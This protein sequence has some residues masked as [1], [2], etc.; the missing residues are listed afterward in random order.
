MSNLL[1]SPRLAT[2]SSLD[3]NYP[4]HDLPGLLQ[5]ARVPASGRLRSL[6]LT[7]GRDALM[8]F[9]RA[10]QP[11]LTQLHFSGWGN[12]EPDWATL[13][14]ANGVEGLRALSLLGLTALDDTKAAMLAGSPR[15]QGLR[16]L[17]V[18]RTSLTATGLASLF[19]L[20]LTY[21]SVQVGQFGTDGLA[22][23]ADTRCR[24]T[25]EELA[26]SLCGG[27]RGWG[28]TLPAGLGL[29]RLRRVALVSCSLSGAG[30]SKL[31]DTPFL[32]GLDVLDL[33]LNGFGAKGLSALTSSG[34]EG[35]RL[36]WLDRC[37]LGDAGM[38]CLARWPGLARVR[39][40]GLGCNRITRAGLI[41]LAE[42][43]HI[44]P[45]E[46]LDLNENEPAMSDG[47][48]ALFR[49]PAGSRLR[50]LSLLGAAPSAVRAITAN[51]PETLRELYLGPSCTSK[52]GPKGMAALRARL[53]ECAIG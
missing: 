53:P 15:L 49:S 27:R 39:Y 3:L 26:L 2:V 31:A 18:E 35:P 11:G 13:F 44:T 30:L 10:L 9:A 5:V 43:P 12:H 4:E 40:L 8:T 7:L 37:A 41:A 21:L 51:A 24:D 36:L 45:L 19:R 42:S 6:R 34:L 46:A 23:L 29:P 14:E 20:P 16:R 38:R 25:L 48:Q 32:G 50:W 17:T 52:V 1:A 47:L 22:R 33:G 28:G